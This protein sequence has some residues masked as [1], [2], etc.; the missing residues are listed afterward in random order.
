MNSPLVDLLHILLCQEDHEYDMM[1][2]PTRD[3]SKCY[4]Y[5]ECDISG[6]HD[7]PDHLKWLTI[8]HKLKLSLGFSSDEDTLEFVKEIVRISKRIRDL[9]DS[10]SI[11]EQFIK[12]I[13]Y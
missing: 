3:E 4:Y 13:L 10:D 11:K 7:M 5:L 9:S 1:K 8:T 6:G 12:S 2:F